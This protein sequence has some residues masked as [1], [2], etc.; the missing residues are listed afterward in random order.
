MSTTRLTFL[1]PPIF[2]SL[3]IS[4]PISRNLC[5]RPTSSPLPCLRKQQFGLVTGRRAQRFAPRVGKAVEPIVHEEEE[6]VGG[7][8]STRGEAKDIDEISR[9]QMPRDISPSPVGSLYE[10]TQAAVRLP[11]DADL[12]SSTKPN[13]EDTEMPKQSI[14]SGGGD[15]MSPGPIE[16]VLEMPMPETAEE[17]NAAKPPHLQTPPYL[18]HFDTYTLV[19]QVQGGG[20]TTA[21][22]IT[23][24]KAVR[25]LLALNLDV[26]RAGLVSKSDV[27]NVSQ[28]RS[29]NWQS[30]LISGVVGIIFV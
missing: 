20:F 19:Q 1:Y 26:A 17:E 23:S 5:L 18:H 25:G 16:T 11:G 21:Q 15:S 8:E 14:G 7:I 22:A 30:C 28:E 10:E 6:E 9:E 29:C 4:E 12:L 27:E 13:I 3:R 2:R 24:M